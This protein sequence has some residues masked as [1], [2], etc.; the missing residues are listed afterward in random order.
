MI[1][2]SNDTLNTMKG[3]WSKFKL[4]EDKIE[5]PHMYLGAEFSKMTNV[6]GQEC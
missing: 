2:I 4:K 6:D 5:E 3:M 1:C